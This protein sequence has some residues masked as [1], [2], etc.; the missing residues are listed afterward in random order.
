MVK[1]KPSAELAPAHRKY[2]LENNHVWDHC[3]S[4]G[5]LLCTSSNLLCLVELLHGSE[6]H[7]ADDAV[8]LLVPGLSVAWFY[9]RL[10]NRSDSLAGLFPQLI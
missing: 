9:S 2:P 7:G 10:L 5:L 3:C 4:V 6:M 8:A 1:E